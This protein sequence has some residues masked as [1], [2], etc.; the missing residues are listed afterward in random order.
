M[1]AEILKEKLPTATIREIARWIREDWKKVFY[2]ANPYL[3]AMMQMEKVSDKYG[4]DD[5]ESIVLYF[6]A[7]ASTWRGPVAR[8]VK[9]EL[10]K[11]IK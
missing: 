6:L 4:W 2:G 9:A 10:N 1:N 11:R 7:N 8:L 5:G 3:Q